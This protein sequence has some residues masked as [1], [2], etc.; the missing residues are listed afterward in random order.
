MRGLAYW[1]QDTVDSAIQSLKDK[2]AQFTAAYDQLTSIEDRISVYPDL[3]DQWSTLKSRGDDIKA[4][5][6]TIASAVD[7][8]GAFLAQTFGLSGLSS[9]GVLPII[10]IAGIA[11][12]TAAVMW[13]ISSVSDILDALNRREMTAKGYT[14]AQIAAATAPTMSANISN[15]VLYGG[16]AIF[17]IVVIP[18]LLERMD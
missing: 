16:L 2:G 17:G 10:P 3:Y 8:A 14:P 6:S 18:K 13:F 7:S 12:A 15:I 5:I 11:A 4:T 9:I 1:G